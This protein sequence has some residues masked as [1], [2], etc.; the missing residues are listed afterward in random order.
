MI[1]AL[2]MPMFHT[3]CDVYVHGGGAVTLLDVPVGGNR[4]VEEF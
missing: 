1:S 2:M 3:L 4:V